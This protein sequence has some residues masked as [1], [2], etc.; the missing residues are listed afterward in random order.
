MHPVVGAQG[1]REP[2]EVLGEAAGALQ[3][4]GA[5]VDEGGVPEDVR[6]KARVGDLRRHLQGLVDPVAGLLE[7]ARFGRAQ[8]LRLRRDH[9][10]RGIPERC[11]EPPGL[12]GLFAAP[13]GLR[14]RLRELSPRARRRVGLRELERPRQPLVAE[15]ARRRLLPEV[16]PAEPV[17]GESARRRRRRRRDPAREPG[18]PPSPRE[19]RRRRSA[20]CAPPRAGAGSRSSPPAQARARARGGGARAPRPA[21]S[22]RRPARP[23]AGATAPRARTPRGGPRARPPR[24]GR[25]PRAAR[26][27]RSAERAEARPRRGRRRAA[28]AT[29][30][31][32]RACARAPALSATRRRPRA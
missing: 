17:V 20:A 15:L 5:D 25:H 7:P 8:A 1:F 18:L 24:R 23:R 4:T 10:E 13:G 3:A 16:G 32:R 9:D 12:F 29:R 31:R 19:S 14:K 22:A 30:R 11:A 28:R 21:R 27:P 2:L 6:P 26:P